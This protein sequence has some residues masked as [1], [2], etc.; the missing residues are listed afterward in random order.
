M[1][2]LRRNET[3]CC[4]ASGE[5]FGSQRP[6]LS[7][8]HTPLLR[9]VCGAGGV[10]ADLSA[11]SLEGYKIAGAI[12][13]QEINLTPPLPFPPTPPPSPSPALC[14]RILFFWLP[15]I[16][17]FFESSTCEALRFPLDLHQLNCSFPARLLRKPIRKHSASS[18]GSWG[19]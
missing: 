11:F 14:P 9:R 13:N 2:R 7:H 1:C 15:F 19:K 4:H 12:K 16:Q 8:T 3:P 5:E 10:C 17:T 18:G 6:P